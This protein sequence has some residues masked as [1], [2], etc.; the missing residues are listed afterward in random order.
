MDNNFFNRD[1]EKVARELLGKILVR[2]IDNNLLKAR[3]V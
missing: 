1:A 3:I 2:K